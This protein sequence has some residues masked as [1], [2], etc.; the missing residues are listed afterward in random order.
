MRRL[1]HA[2]GRNK[3]YEFILFS[4]FLLFFYGPLLHMSLLAFAEEFQFPDM[5]PRTYGFRWWDFVLSNSRLVAS[6]TQSLLIAVIVTAISLAICLPAAYA[7]GRYQFKGRN[8]VR[9]SFL[10]TNAFPRIG[11][12]TAMA[13]VFYQL[14][15]MGTLLGVVLVHVVNSM[16]FLIW[17]SAGSFRTVHKSLEESARDLGATPFR[18]FLHVTLPL[19]WP[20][21]VVASMFT[22]L[23]SME[24]MEGTLL[25]GL[26]TIRTM[27]TELY[28]LIQAFPQTAG[29]AFAMM[30]LIPTIIAL[31]LCRKYFSAST[32]SK[33]IK[34]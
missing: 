14:Q 18:T 15:L 17:I 21:I 33:G 13:I 20:G 22:F 10:F 5:I 2:L 8:F 34:M 30:L 6:I 7:I 11:I 25:I 12:Y 28:G 19:A 29:A 26:P 9:M 3:F 32:I 16:M 4:V 31:V 1:Y 24:E 23:G 27:P